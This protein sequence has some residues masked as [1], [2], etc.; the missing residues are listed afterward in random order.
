[1]APESLAHSDPLRIMKMVCLLHCISLIPSTCHA[2]DFN[3]LC[4]ANSSLEPF[5]QPSF[6]ANF[7]LLLNL[8]T[9]SA[10]GTFVHLADYF[11]SF[12]SKVCSSYSSGFFENPSGSRILECIK[13][14]HSIKAEEV[15][16]LT[17]LIDI[18]DY[19][20]SFKVYF[21]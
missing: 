5:D 20:R 8:F 9:A 6:N 12:L 4:F 13:S 18:S 15:F 10:E 11:L 7:F 21:I 19:T 2:G 3:C 17:L 14:I 16:L 1:M